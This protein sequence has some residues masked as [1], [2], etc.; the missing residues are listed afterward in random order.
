DSSSSKK[1]VSEDEHTPGEIKLEAQFVN[2]IISAIDR[3]N[4][5]IPGL[6]KD[7]FRIYEDGVL[8]SV[9]LFST[10]RTPFNLIL[11]LDLSGSV[12]DRSQF[13]K[14]VSLHFLDVVSPNDNVGLV[15]FSTDVTVISHLTNDRQKL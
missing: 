15:S 6:S 12:E 2:L 11:L 7:D 13:M 5:A 8:Q 1:N 3:D 9:S 14:E 10:E 4:K